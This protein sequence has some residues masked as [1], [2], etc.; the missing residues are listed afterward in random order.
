MAA[1]GRCV[2]RVQPRAQP[3]IGVG[4]AEV[5]GGVETDPAEAVHPELRPGVR[6]AVVAAFFGG[7]VVA[8]DIAR[9]PAERAGGGDHHMGVVLTDAFARRQRRRRR[10]RGVAGAGAI[11]DARGH[12][13]LQG[14]GAFDG[15]AAGGVGFV[16]QRQDGGVGAGARR[17][18]Q[19]DA[20]F[21]RRAMAAQHAGE[22]GGLDHALGD[23]LHRR[24]AAAQEQRRHRVAIAVAKVRLH[25]AVVERDPPG[26]R[27]LAVE[28]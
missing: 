13:V 20:G 14:V 2:R 8:S 28:D 4:G 24:H 22:V 19:A 15:R 3:H 27:F 6:G 18:A 10:G 23:H 21:Q 9:G 12:Q 25:H 7:E 11:G 26:E 16:R 17:L 5:V 1:Q